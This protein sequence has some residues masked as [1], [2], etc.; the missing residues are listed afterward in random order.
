MVGRV[1]VV[2]VR[3]VGCQ[4]MSRG[5]GPCGGCDDKGDTA[6]AAPPMAYAVVRRVPS[7][8]RPVDRCT[9]RQLPS[10]TLSIPASLPSISFRLL[11]F[12]R[13]T[14]SPYHPLAAPVLPL[15]TPLTL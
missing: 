13:V 15:S 10:S 7:T 1:G 2:S 14:S 12:L 8:N 5:A 9:P 3:A 11:A 4:R 6:V